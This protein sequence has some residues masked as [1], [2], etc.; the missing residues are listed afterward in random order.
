MV[1][2]LGSAAAAH[3]IADKVE[4]RRVP[5]FPPQKIHL[6]L[7]PLPLMYMLGMG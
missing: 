6:E 2:G 4:G 1:E 5:Y 7:P 3:C